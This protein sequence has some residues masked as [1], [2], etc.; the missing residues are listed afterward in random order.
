MR[1][2]GI[3]MADTR[4]PSNHFAPR[5]APPKT[6]G[7]AGGQRP[8]RVVALGL[9]VVLAAA[10]IAVSNFYSTPA[11]T[12]PAPA[13][14][15]A[16]ALQAAASV[17]APAVAPKPVPPPAPA[18]TAVPEPPPAPAPPPPEIKPVNAAAKH[19]IY[20]GRTKAGREAMLKE[21]GGTPETE[22][23]VLKALRWF[24]AQQNSV[25]SWGQSQSVAMCGLALQAFLA[26]GE[27]PESEEF[28]DTVHRAIGHLTNQILGSDGQVGGSSY[29]HGIGVCALSEA[30]ALCDLP[31][32]MPAMEKGLKVIVD[33]QQGAGGWD[34]NYKKDQRWDLSVSGWQIQALKTGHL[35]GA[36]TPGLLEA[37]DRAMIFLKKESFSKGS[38]GYDRPGGGSQ[39]MQGAGTFCLQLLGDG[40]GPEAQDGVKWLSANMA[41]DWKN[42]GTLGQGTYAWYY[43]TQ[44]L[45]HAGTDAWPKWNAKLIEQL[46]ARQTDE[47]CWF[48][49]SGGPAGPMGDYDTALQTAFC[50]LM[51]EVYYRYGPMHKQIIASTATSS[52]GP[53]APTDK[54]LKIE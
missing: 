13:G 6:P 16:P 39:A 20:S 52:M 45:Y 28:G 49:P 15:Q 30:C 38:F 11:P 36:Q 42:A 51:L 9:L 17:P 47:G 3:L 14:A 50:T 5:G 41:L 19:F 35:A 25:G 8:G 18:V 37:I 12:P 48:T 31:Q 26:H 34:Y 23:A 46:L 33:G 21:Y 24:K 27:T 4:K 40:L 44:A 10:A 29:A 1:L 32:L 7:A 54:G 2:Y 22:A 43:H 53:T